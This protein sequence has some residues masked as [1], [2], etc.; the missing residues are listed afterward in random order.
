MKGTELL[1][2]RR[3]GEKDVLF[4]SVSVADISKDLAEKG[5][6]IDRRRVML[7]HPIKELGNFEV[8]INVHRDIQVKVPVYVVRPGEEPQRGG[9]NEDPAEVAAEDAAAVVTT[10]DVTPVETADLAAVEP[11]DVVESEAAVE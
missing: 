10:P 8:E 1:F 3:A 6:D 7:E 11:D 9:A 2:E 5:F 4:G